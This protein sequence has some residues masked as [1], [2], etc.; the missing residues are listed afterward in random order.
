MAIQFQGLSTALTMRQEQVLNSLEENIIELNSLIAL[1]NQCTFL[2]QL[3]IYLFDSMQLTLSLFKL[4]ILF[5][6]IENINHHK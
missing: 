1:L 3:H 4:N 2:K 5:S 6:F